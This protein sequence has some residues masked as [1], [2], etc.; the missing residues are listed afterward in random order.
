MKINVSGSIEVGQSFPAYVEEKFDKEVVKF[1]DNI[2]SAD[3]RLK[4]QGPMIFTSI[5]VNDVLKKGVKINAEAEG[6]DAYRSFDEA[7]KKLVIQLRKEKD[8]LV[9]EK[10][11]GTK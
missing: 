5:V 11:K 8:K 3:V 6:E 4:K 7:F 2:P 9:S 1:F 10:K